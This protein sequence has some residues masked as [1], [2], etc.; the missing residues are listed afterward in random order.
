MECPRCG[1]RTYKSLGGKDICPSCGYGSSTGDK[2]PSPAEVGASST[3]YPTHP[4]GDEQASSSPPQGQESVSE[5]TPTTVPPNTRFGLKLFAEVVKSSPN[6]NVFI[7]P[8]SIAL[9]LAMTYNGAKDET[10]QAMAET[11]ELKGMNLQEVNVANAALLAVL[12]DADAK[13]WNMK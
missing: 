11:L 2:A 3:S 9:A 4:R 10:Q 6:G 1:A 12:K 8:S 7:S 5:S 13:R